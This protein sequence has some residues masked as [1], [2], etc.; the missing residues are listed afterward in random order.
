ML[1]AAESAVTHII[2]ADTIEVD[3]ILYDTPSIRF[4]PIIVRSLIYIYIYIYV[5]SSVINI[6]VF[7]HKMHIMPTGSTF[8]RIDPCAGT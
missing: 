1:T 3:K 5:Y 4:D 2:S 6:T 7:F 8:R